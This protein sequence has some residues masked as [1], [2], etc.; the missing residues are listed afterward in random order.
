MM[1]MMNPGRWTLENVSG[2]KRYLAGEKLWVENIKIEEV[3]ACRVAGQLKK[4]LAVGE[5]RGEH[6]YPMSGWCW[7]DGSW[8]I[9][10]IV[11]GMRR[12][13]SGSAEAEILV[14]ASR[15][16]KAT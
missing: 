7:G 4:Q 13:V 10:R 9:V 3:T 6:Y 16:L 14:C 5:A 2:I 8:E 11:K 15:D 12:K 1:K